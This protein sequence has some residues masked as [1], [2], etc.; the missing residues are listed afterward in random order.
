MILGA[1]RFL[2]AVAE[3]PGFQAV[4][5]ALLGEDIRPESYQRASRSL[6][7][8]AQFSNDWVI[9]AQR[10]I[11][12]HNIGRQASDPDIRAAHYAVSRETAID[13]MRL[14]PV[15]PITWLL[16]AQL[17]YEQQDRVAA[18]EALDWAHQTS[19]YMRHQ[20][21][22]RVI[23]ALSLWDLVSEETRAKSMDAIRDAMQ[24]EIDMVAYL[25]GN[26]AFE[27]DLRERLRASEDNGVMLAARFEAAVRR[28]RQNEQIRRAA[29]EEFLAMRQTLIAT[30]MLVTAS[31]PLFAQAMSVH[32]YLVIRD[33]EHPTRLPD[34]VNDYLAA[35]LDGLLVLGYYNYED[36]NPLFCVPNRHELNINVPE[37]RFNLDALLEEYEREMPNFET[38]A[39]T[40][41]VGLVSLELMTVLYPCEDD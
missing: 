40:R 31:L 13:G 8:A 14:S 25:A 12:E 16:L 9:T 28:Y 18:A 23:L 15:Q 22:E 37:F 27:D 39:R 10:A 41:S 2:A 33:G 4:Q 3:W 1:P 21:R 17:A 38:L 26:G 24:R 19:H 30:S 36:G 35:V 20:A 11:I 32:D 34:D 5:L 6:E 29:Y 7:N